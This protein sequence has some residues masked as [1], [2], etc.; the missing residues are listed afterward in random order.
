MRDIDLKLK[1]FSGRPINAL[2]YGDII[3]LTVKDIVDVGYSE[4]MKCLNILTLDSNDFLDEPTDIHVLE[5]ILNH[6]GREI[7]I[8]FEDA[9]KLFFRGEAVLDKDEIRVFVN[10]S[11]NEVKVIDKENYYEIQEIL[12][13]QNYIN[14]FEEKKIEESFNPV[15]EETRKLKEQMDAISKKRDELKKKKSQNAEQEDSEGSEIDFYDILSAI[16]SKAYGINELNVID[17]TVYQVYRKFKRME[18]IDQY[19]LSI[20]SILAG[21]QNIKIKHWSSKD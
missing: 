5:L 12:K 8:V 2:G 3:P 1:L 13:W 14:S 7:E 16:S 9:I 17:M 11:E 21:A 4:Y 19:D 15:D 20:K 18:I 10:I 6:A